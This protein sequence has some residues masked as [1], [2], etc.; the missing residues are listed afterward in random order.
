MLHS[1]VDLA[2]SPTQGSP[3]AAVAVAYYRVSRQRQALS[4][5]G[6]DAQRH[7]VEAY[8]RHHGLELVESF[9]EVETGTS[10]RKRV[11]IHKAISAAQRLGAV[12]LIGKL[13]RLARNVAFT[14]NLMES[15]V[16][17]VA[18]DMPDANRLTVHIMAALAEHEAR[19]ISQRTKDALAQAK[20]R[21]TP[22]GRPENLDHRDR[23]KGASVNAARA[24]QAARHVYGYVKVLRDEGW[25]FNRIAARLND[26]GFVTR[27]GS[28]WHA[29]Q[30][31]R[32]LDRQ[33]AE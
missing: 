11:E 22:L 9:V 16:N 8:A 28:A 2:V 12:L 33:Q 14:S 15:G 31:K 21:G 4:G 20:A 26:E 24:R 29:M 1:G 18:V 10:R 23:L 30:V 25:S 3:G 27:R 13:D 17:F 32:V 6:L 19:L 5:L 7:D